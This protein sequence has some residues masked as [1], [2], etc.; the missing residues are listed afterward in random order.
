MTTIS[1]ASKSAKATIEKHKK[2]LAQPDKQSSKLDKQSSK[3]D[4]QLDKQDTKKIKS[5]GGKES[6][7]SSVIS[8]TSTSTSRKRESSAYNIYMST[9]IPKIKE[10][11][12][13]KKLTRKELMTILSERW[14]AHKK[15]I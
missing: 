2:L 1:S 8:N 15:V 9:E 11:N 10:D 12:K 6:D 7:T 5:N 14:A 13:D 4:R 3:L